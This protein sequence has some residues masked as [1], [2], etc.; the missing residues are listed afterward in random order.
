[1]NTTH[2]S[3]SQKPKHVNDWAYNCAIGL[4]DRL[5]TETI[6]IFVYR[7]MSGIAAATALSISYYLLTGQTPGMIYVRKKNEKSHGYP[8]EYQIDF[9]PDRQ[10]VFVFVDDFVKSGTTRREAF[11]EIFNW[12]RKDY[13]YTKIDMLNMFQC[14]SY[15][16]PVYYESVEMVEEFASTLFKFWKTDKIAEW[17]IE[18]EEA[19]IRK[20]KILSTW[21]E[22]STG[23]AAP[24]EYINSF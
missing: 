22:N 12:V 15:M 3:N 14:L 20:G 11:K 13:R 24:V 19:E 6:P 23:A 5:G 4:K 18:D 16:S 17:K 10:Y 21:L 8:V 2:Y 7:G 9:F 1:M